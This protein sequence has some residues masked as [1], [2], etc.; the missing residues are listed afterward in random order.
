MFITICMI[1]LKFYPITALM[2]V[3]LAILNDLLPILAAAYDN[4]K[5][6]QEPKNWNMKYIILP[7]LHSGHHRRHISR[8]PVSSSPTD[9]LD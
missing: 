6:A 1:V 9:F 4:V 2:I 7:G 8:L 3:L 5:V